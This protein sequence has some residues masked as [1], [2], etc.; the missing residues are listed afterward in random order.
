[1]VLF[2][3]FRMTSPSMTSST[4]LWASSSW[5]LA[6]ERIRFMLS[7]STCRVSS[8]SVRRVC[9]RR[10]L[11]MVWRLFFTRWW[12]SLMATDLRI[13][14]CSCSRRQVTS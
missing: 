5:V 8:L 1:M 4:P 10:R 12:I 3:M 11:A 6:M 9:R 2:F 13:S 7:P 14:A